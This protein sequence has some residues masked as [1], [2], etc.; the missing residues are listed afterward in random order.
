MV[1]GS[2]YLN[3]G[4]SFFLLQFAWKIKAVSEDI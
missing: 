2:L 3:N 1:T 4:V